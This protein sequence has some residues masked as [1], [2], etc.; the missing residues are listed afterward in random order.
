MRGIRKTKKSRSVKKTKT[1]RVWNQKGCSP[2]TKRHSY[3]NKNLKRGGGCGCGNMPFLGGGCA[4]CQKGGTTALVGAPW[5]PQIS[6]WPGVQGIDGQTNYYPLNQY[7][8]D[9]Q[10]QTMQERLGS[11]FLGKYTGGKKRAKTTKKRGGGLIPQDLANF[12]NTVYYGLGSAYNSING[13]P[14][15]VSP[16]PYQDQFLPRNTMR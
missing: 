7:H 10:L 4:L 15:P 2:N 14:Q 13:Y 8:V 12:G 11:V 9:P 5:T 16:L 6:G 1:Q 3:K